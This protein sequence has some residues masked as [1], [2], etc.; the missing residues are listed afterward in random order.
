MRN[1][2]LNRN[3]KWCKA[4]NLDKIWTLV[5]EDTRLRCLASKEKKAP[6]IDVVKAVSVTANLLSILKLLLQIQNYY[7]LLWFL[8]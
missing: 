1:Y 6:V 4:I 7:Y 3:T 2:H 5:N 8:I